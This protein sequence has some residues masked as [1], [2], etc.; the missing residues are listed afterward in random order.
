MIKKIWDGIKELAKPSSPELSDT[1]TTEKEYPKYYRKFYNFP[2]LTNDSKTFK[3]DGLI[4]KYKNP[5]LVH[6]EIAQQARSIVT[7]IGVLQGCVETLKS[8]ILGERGL[9][10]DLNTTNHELNDIVEKRFANW[11]IDVGNNKTFYK[12][13]HEVLHHYLVD[14]E[15]FVYLRN[16]ENKFSLQVLDTF[17]LSQIVKEKKNI[18]YGIQF[19]KL[20][21]PINYFFQK[22]PIV[23]TLPLN[24]A[25][26]IKIPAENIIHFKYG[27]NVR[28]LSHFASVIDLSYD[29]RNLTKEQIKRG[30]LSSEFI[31]YMKTPLGYDPSCGEYNKGLYQDPVTGEIGSKPVD[32][33]EK[34][35]Y[36][37]EP[38]TLPVLPAGFEP[39]IESPVE[40]PDLHKYLMN[41]Y[42]NASSALG[43]T[44]PTFTG[45]LS[46]VNYSS[47]RAGSLKERRLFGVK[48]T[49]L[50]D[51]VLSKV[52]ITWLK[53]P[54]NYGGVKA[55]T[56][57]AN[58][59]ENF[60]FKRPTWQHVDPVKEA[61]AMKIQL[62]QGLLTLT[63]LLKN[64]GKDVDEHYQELEDDL[65]LI[66]IVAAKNTMMD[67]VADNEIQPEEDD[68]EKP[69]KKSNST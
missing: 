16:E 39:H 58:I 40:P 11:C 13:Q 21:T 68:E 6:L 49:F 32:D 29:A 33:L 60:S 50:I 43:L 53:H 14:G 5:D 44:Y 45:D 57:V 42:Y 65:K 66:N 69:K 55:N 61:N 30:I 3:Y 20:G 9:I 64:R 12:F 23:Q 2:S 54:S 63:E 25:D 8:E 31:G 10:L 52:F 17:R 7:S 28:G 38:G 19:D 36:G 26:L 41:Y 4:S 48:Q 1:V 46:E 56:A 51:E 15:V 24:E 27:T 59:I 62:E 34:E 35:G 67:Q 37:I 18:Y 22:A 47:I